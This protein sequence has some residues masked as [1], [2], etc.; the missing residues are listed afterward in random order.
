MFL[1]GNGS[2]NMILINERVNGCSLFED[3][4]HRLL[5][6][7]TVTH[8]ARTS[9]PA[10]RVPGAGVPTAMPRGSPGGGVPVLT[11]GTCRGTASHTGVRRDSAGTRMLEDTFTE[12]RHHPHGA[13]TTHHSTLRCTPYPHHPRHRLLHAAIQGPRVFSHPAACKASGE[14]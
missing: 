8:R 11:G 1:V 2:V 9:S 13:H 10:Q 14:K 3:N 7:S 4:S 5:D 12:P 6:A